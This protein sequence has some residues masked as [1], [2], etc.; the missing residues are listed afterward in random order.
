MEFNWESYVSLSERIL[1]WCEKD[2]K[3]ACLRTS[4][5]R[6]YYGVFCTARNKLIAEGVIIPKVSTHKFVRE[7]YQASKNKF[8]KKIG[9]NL[10]RL[11]AERKA[12]DYEDKAE[13]SIQRAKIAIEI[14]KRTL[15]EL[16]KI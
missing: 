15:K 3:E 4:I 2:L 6:A 16:K 8:K 7:K 1:S 10:K 5:S 12:A 14:A 11:W 13:I 9:K